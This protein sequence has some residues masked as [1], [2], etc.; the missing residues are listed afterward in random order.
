MAKTNG[1]IHIVDIRY[2]PQKNLP[3]I[4][5]VYMGLFLI[6]DGTNNE[7]VLVG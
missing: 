5:T 1:K 6:K 2:S 3:I 4:S 7:W